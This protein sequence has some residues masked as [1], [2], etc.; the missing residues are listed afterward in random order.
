VIA[1]PVAGGVVDRVSRG[2]A[3]AEHLSGW[4]LQGS[5]CRQ[6]LV[7]ES[8]DLVGAH[9][10]MPSAPR[11]RLEYPTERHPSLDGARRTDRRCVGEQLGLT[12]AEHDVGR[13]R[14]PGEPCT[15]RDDGCHR[16]DHDFACIPE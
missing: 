14:Q 6:V 13:E 7:A 15:D 5:E 10:D 11:Q 1:D 4:V 8:V 3:D 12:V 16:T 9:D 2:A